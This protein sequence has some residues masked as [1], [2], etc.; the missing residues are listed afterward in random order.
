MAIETELKLRI[1]PEHLARLKRH[2]LLKAH[3]LARPATHRLY[4]I[5]YDTPKL[6]LHHSEMALRLRRSGSHW[7]QTLKGGGSVQAGLHQ[8]SEW[9]IPVSGPA[10]EF[11]SAQSAEWDEHL[12]EKLRN[13]LQ[14]VFVTDF[15][16]SS[17]MLSW[18]GAQIEL[19][20]DQGEVSTEQHRV[21]ICELELELKSGEPRQLFE[22]ALA[23]LKIVPF[24]LEVV[25]KAEQG[26]RLLSGD[27][28]HPVK[29]S[30]PDI[31]EKDTLAE[32]LQ[33]LLWSCVQHLQANL[34]G[35]MSSADA[36]YLHQMRVALR[37]MRVVLRITE[38]ICPDVQLATLSREVAALCVA[39]GRIREWDVF[40][41][42]TV[43]PM[44]A[45]MAGHGG[46]QALL[47]SSERQRADCYAALRGGTQARELQRLLLRFAIWMNGNYWQKAPL[48][49][50]ARDFAS[51]RLHRLA[52]RLA[53]SG[54]GLKSFD[55]TGLHALRILGKKLRYSAE[56][57]SGW[58]ERKATRSFLAALSE[59][60]EVLGQ[61]NDVAVAHRLLDELAASADLAV[62]Q[63]ALVLAKGWI[64]HDLSRQ[65]ALLHKALRRFNKQP[66]F[67]QP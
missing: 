63:E 57:F 62:H 60:Q 10:L 66:A 19:C 1:S 11:S 15:S 47:A 39:L 51:R 24:E 44:C 42:G 67:W 65:F 25:S 29:A 4:N 32:V 27:V 52:K 5:Y 2:A 46:L 8:R 36:E 50:P 43:Q 33:T 6:E 20:M 12:P 3:T 48:L 31:A 58:Y 21:P 16:R 38:K 64:A 30:A 9:E 28:D 59:V 41:S 54:R 35:A 14:P 22:L 26:Y 37:R 34:R 53:E 45:R 40:I 7:L 61:I 49:A 56:F 18:Q 23:L 13:K 55:A 17:R